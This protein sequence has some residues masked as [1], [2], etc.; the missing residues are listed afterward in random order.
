MNQIEI[1]EIGIK[2]N[3]SLLITGAAG[4][5]KSACVRAAAERFGMP[6]EIVLLSGILPEDIGGLVRPS[7]DGRS[8][9]YLPPAWF[10]KYMDGNR[11]FVVFFDEINQASIQTLHALFYAVNDRTVAGVA[12]PNMRVVA[13][14]NLDSENEWLTPIPAPL[15]DRFVYKIEWSGDI[16]QSIAW[17]RE[18]YQA[19]EAILLLDVA[20]KTSTEALTARHLEQAIWLLADGTATPQHMTTLLGEATYTA[21][22]KASAA[23][24][25]AEDDRMRELA[26]IRAKYNSGLPFEIVNGVMR[27]IDRDTILNGLTPEEVELV[28]A[29]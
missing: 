22:I 29:A 3:R 26:E 7:A 19:P 27:G 12:N 8:F 11:P 18:K 6:V 5:A 16:A 15:L 20:E 28:T 24:R 17:L 13:A 10:A 21:F 9:G 1:I 4:T 14:G 25:H 2:N 23:P